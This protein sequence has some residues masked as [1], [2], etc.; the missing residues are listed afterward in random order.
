MAADLLPRMFPM[1]TTAAGTITPARV[2]II[3]AGVAGLA[4]HRHGAAA[5]R[6]RLGLRHAGRLEGAGPESGRAVRRAGGRGQDAQDARGY[7]KA[8]G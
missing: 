1:M 3:G 6:R 8:P 4:G 2:L 5:G 7:G